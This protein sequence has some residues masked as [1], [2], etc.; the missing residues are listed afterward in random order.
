M[1]LTRNQLS[2][3]RVPGVRIPPSPPYVKYVRV[4]AVDA[5]IALV[6][7][8]AKLSTLKD[9]RITVRTIMRVNHIGGLVL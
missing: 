4:G 3:L 9:Q 8:L 5:R 6:H 7:Q 1:G 2:V